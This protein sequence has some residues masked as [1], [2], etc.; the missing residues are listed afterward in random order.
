[1]TRERYRIGEAAVL[2]R[3]RDTALAV[4]RKKGYAVAELAVLPDHLHAA[5]RGNVEASPEVIAL[6]F[7]NNLAYALGQRAVWQFGYYA[8][9]FG[10]YGMRAV[11][12]PS[13]PA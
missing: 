10:E 2:T 4:A 8:G 3:V 5:L 13:P 1:V 9:T 11:R 12:V 6:S 7:L